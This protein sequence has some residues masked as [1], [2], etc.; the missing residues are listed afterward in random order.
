MILDPSDI[1]RGI[2]HLL[3]PNSEIAL[4]QTTRGVVLQLHFLLNNRNLWRERE[5]RDERRDGRRRGRKRGNGGVR[6]GAGRAQ[7]RARAARTPPFYGPE[8]RRVRA[9]R[10][11]PATRAR[12][13]VTILIVILLGFA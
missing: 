9:S 6:V 8:R 10:R 5:T 2:S 1:D 11:A 12:L 7:R 3:G 4:D 13:Q